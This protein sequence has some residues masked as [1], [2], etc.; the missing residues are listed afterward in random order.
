[1]L[2]YFYLS[3][4]N[5]FRKRDES[6]ESDPVAAVVAKLTIPA[7]TYTP[8]L[9]SIDPSDQKKLMQ[10]ELNLRKF[11]EDRRRFELERL[12]F[13]QQKRELDRMRLAR[14][15]KYKTDVIG[16]EPHLL[17]PAQSFRTH[18][19]SPVSKR[20]RSKSSH[21]SKPKRVLDYESSTVETS[22]IPSEDDGKSLDENGNIKDSFRKT[23]EKEINDHHKQSERL[24]PGFEF[25]VRRRSA[26]SRHRSSSRSRHSKELKM[27]SAPTTPAPDVLLTPPD[28]GKLPDEVNGDVKKEDAGVSDEKKDE[29]KS[30]LVPKAVE[31]EFK[32][33]EDEKLL[34]KKGLKA[35]IIPVVRDIRLTWRQLKAARPREWCQIKAQI[36]KCFA[37]LLVLTIFVGVGGLMFR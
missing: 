19:D 32:D 16:R 15:E 10:L 31:E 9:S 23:V 8:Q 29:V 14:F 6:S 21:K 4:L 33:V 12:R 28:T 3:P 37:Q 30:K 5:F 17:A 20:T 25:Q 11:E 27:A 7:P 34:P 18:T 24:D 1:M 2:A 26:S 35:R 36:R 22:D 13:I